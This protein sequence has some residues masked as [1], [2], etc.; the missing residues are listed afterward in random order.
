VIISHLSNETQKILRKT[1]PQKTL[2][3]YIKFC[4]HSNM[5]FLYDLIKFSAGHFDEFESTFIANKILEQFINKNTRFT[6]L[7]FSSAYYLYHM[8][9]LISKFKYCFS[10]LEF[11]INKIKYNQGTLEELAKICKS[12]KKVELIKD[13]GDWSSKILKLIEAQNNINSI[14]CHNNHDSDKDVLFKTPSKVFIEHN[15]INLTL[16]YG[17][18]FYFKNIP[19]P[20]LKF[21]KF[22]WI[23]TENLSKLSRSQVS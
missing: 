19:L 13:W 15:L 21:L 16:E 23:S 18:D 5:Q 20:N 1:T 10:D 4:R 3:N 14:A 7:Y 11:L 8:H 2:F 9:D 22:R 12:I 6:H 17:N